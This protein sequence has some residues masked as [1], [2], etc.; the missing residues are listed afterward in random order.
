MRPPVAPWP[1]TGRGT[2][3]VPRMPRTPW[4]LSWS[5]SRVTGAV[6][7]EELMDLVV[8]WSVDLMFHQFTIRPLSMEAQG[9]DSDPRLRSRVLRSQPGHLVGEFP[10]LSLPPILRLCRCRSY[11][12]SWDWLN[13]TRPSLGHVCCR[14]SSIKASRHSP[15]ETRGAVPPL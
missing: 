6:W 15:R 10:R 2:H 8:S 9:E 14:V 11:P 3:S 13:R 1:Q 12:I 7:R 5:P 4:G